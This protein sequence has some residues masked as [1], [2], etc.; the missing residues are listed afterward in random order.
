MYTGLPVMEL[1][2]EGW[3]TAEDPRL[4]ICQANLIYHPVFPLEVASLDGLH[5]SKTVASN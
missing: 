4:E 1:W 5:R 2:G 3:V